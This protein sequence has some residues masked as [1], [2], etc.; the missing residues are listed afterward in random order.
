MAILWIRF[1]EWYAEELKIQ[2]IIIIIKIVEL[3]Y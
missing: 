3:H 1:W 2:N